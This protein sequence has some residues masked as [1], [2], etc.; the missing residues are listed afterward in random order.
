MLLLQHRGEP[1]AGWL[2]FTL[3]VGMV[4]NIDRKLNFEGFVPIGAVSR[5]SL[6]RPIWIWKSLETLIF[7]T[8]FESG[9]G[10][11]KGNGGGLWEA[12]VAIA[13]NGH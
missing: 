1:K 10:D 3:V 2:R 13:L 7:L 12:P 4:P 11:S 8:G 9:G 6:S 5:L